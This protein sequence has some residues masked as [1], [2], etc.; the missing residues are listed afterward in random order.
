MCELLHLDRAQLSNPSFLVSL[1]FAMLSNP[2]NQDSLDLQRYWLI[3][4]RRW[5]A[6]FMALGSVFGLTIALTY[7][8]KPIFEAEGTLLFN[9]TNRVSSLSGTME[10][11]GELSGLTQLSNPLDTESEI[12]RSTPL[13]QKTIARL[14]LKDADGKP[15][16]VEEF[17]KKLKVKSIRGTD[18][19]ELSYRSTNAKEAAMVVNLLTQN[20]LESNVRMNRAEAVAAREF[21]SKELPT[22]EARVS[23][24]ESYLRQFKEANRVVSLDE[25][26]KTMVTGLSDLADQIT[27][28]QAELADTTS[29]ARSMQNQLDLN[30]QQAIALTSL[31]QS[32]QVQQVLNDYRQV[33]NQLAVQQA[34]Y[35]DG[36]PLIANLKRREAALKTQLDKRVTQTLGNPQ[37]V[38]DQNLQISQL[39]Q[40]MTAE[41]VKLEVDRRGLENRVTVLRNAY[42]FN[43]NRANVLPRLEQTQRGLE[44][45]LQVARSTYEELLK[46]L[47]D[48]Q[49]VENQNVGNARVISAAMVPNRPISPRILLN[50]ALGGFLG[51]L[52]GLSVMVILEAID[53]SVKTTDEAKRLLDFPLLGTIPRF[54]QKLGEGAAIVPVRD[55]PYSPVSA[56]F[57]MLQTTLGF[58][59]T[60]RA[61][62]VVLVTSALP[63]E[64]KSFV[65]ANLA[66]SNAQMG[67]R[68]LLIDADMR[69]PSQHGIWDLPNFKGLSDVLVGQAEYRTSVAEGLINLDILTA[70]T[71]PP[72][73]MAL[74]SSKRIAAVIEAAK[75]DYDF[76]IIDTP[77]I[78]LAADGLT[79]GK[80]ADGVLLVVRPG[81]VNSGAI[82]AAKSLLNQS[83]QRVL[84][85]VVN[86]VIPKNESGSYY[87]VDRYYGYRPTIKLTGDVRQKM[88]DRRP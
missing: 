15:L 8:Q 7:L 48:V 41:L 43:Q 45:R 47:Q 57:E 50:L 68:V 66:V 73:P 29:R 61:L 44:R 63:T 21:I 23:E 55:N 22:V 76:I 71:I 3:F 19:L 17:L 82:A 59:M 25:E 79:L 2:E 10:K 75:A 84:G 33:Q 20:Y 56:A 38:A 60:D 4:K 16:T 85:M 52:A 9:K 74:L 40:G 27:K 67:R 86:G 69:R 37:V 87:G 24:A 1:G 46:R 13:I 31:S 64:G 70:G 28:A 18:V 34:R 77:P 80:L 42:V 35:Q 51:I 39:K 72:N 12:I 30:A 62:K 36:H 83:G 11:A 49:V 26:A 32:T 14:K 53:K 78:A 58:T 6:G 5:L 54:S 65:A 81:V 88:L